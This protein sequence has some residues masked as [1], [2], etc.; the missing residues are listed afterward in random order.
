MH[1]LDFFFFF[2]LAVYGKCQWVSVVLYLKGIDN[3]CVALTAKHWLK[4]I[5]NTHSCV[6]RTPV[7][8]KKERFYVSSCVGLNVL[9]KTKWNGGRFVILSIVTMKFTLWITLCF[10]T[11]QTLRRFRRNVRGHHNITIFKSSGYLE[12]FWA[13]MAIF[14]KEV[15]QSSTPLSFQV[16]TVPQE[17]R[18]LK[19]TV[20]EGAELQA[21]CLLVRQVIE[22]WFL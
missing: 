9:I 21:E 12:C 17:K 1:N 13:D 18:T 14:G 7:F 16:S 5:F 8:L 22:E 2:F 3:I 19:S 6:G 11:H 20:P 4:Y 15:N 10:Y